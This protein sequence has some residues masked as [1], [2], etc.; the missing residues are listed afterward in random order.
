MKIEIHQHQWIQGFQC[1]KFKTLHIILTRA[2]P[3]ALKLLSQ[4]QNGKYITY[5]LTITQADRAV[6][7]LLP[8]KLAIQSL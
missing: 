4:S 2:Q 5:V 7:L 8:K 1:F 6:D 3:A